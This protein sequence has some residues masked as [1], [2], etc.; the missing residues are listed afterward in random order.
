M[1]KSNLKFIGDSDGED[2]RD[3]GNLKSGMGMGTRMIPAPDP[4]KSGMGLGPPF[5]SEPESDSESPG[6]FIG[7]GTPGDRGFHALRH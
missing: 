5:P 4:G 7:D 3:S 1:L 6:K 2:P